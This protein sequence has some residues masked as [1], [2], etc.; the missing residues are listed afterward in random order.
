MRA[1]AR[2]R[3]ASS[4]MSLE[5]PRLKDI[6]AHRD[7]D[8]LDVTLAGAVREMLLPEA[9]AVHRCIGEMGQ[10]RWLTRARL[11]EGE[12]AAAVD[13]SWADLDMQPTIDDEPEWRDCMLNQAIMVSSDGDN[14]T[15]L[16]PLVT[17]HETVGVLEVTSDQPLNEQQMRSLRSVL[18]IYRSFQALID[19]SERDTLTGLLNRRT[20]DD[21]FA[22]FAA[23]TNNEPTPSG[24][25]RR[26]LTAEASRQAHHFL[27]V[28]DIDHFKDVN[29]GHGHLLGD[30][31]LL[32]IAR[33]MRATFRQHDRLY[34][35]GGEE[36]VVLLRCAD[37][38]NARSALERFRRNVEHYGFPQVGRVTVSVG[39]TTI[40]SDDNP[41]EAFDR[42][43]RAVYRAKHGGRNQ[44][45]CFEDTLPNC[46]PDA[47]GRLTAPS[48]L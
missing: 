20:F 32:L 40:A 27:G 15:T 6:A 25:E 33:L 31:V 23:L 24:M 9:V 14:V 22:M 38:Q 13:S 3:E 8:V 39:F 26:S 37:A 45:C 41:N 4:V 7:R 42:A 10:R 17:E 19:N 47:G 1:Q 16:L 5:Q 35:F 48:A 36:F 28:I 43:D 44:V 2:S 21:S 12:A 30:E 46:H 29:D 18:H 11:V 34:R